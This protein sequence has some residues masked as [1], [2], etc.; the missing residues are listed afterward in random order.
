MYVYTHSKS[1]SLTISKVEV[2]VYGS[3]M[4]GESHRQGLCRSACCNV[5]PS[6]P[7]LGPRPLALSTGRAAPQRVSQQKGLAET[8]ALGMRKRRE[9]RLACCSIVLPSVMHAGEHYTRSLSMHN[10]YTPKE[11]VRALA[12]TLRVPVRVLF[13]Q[14]ERMRLSHDGNLAVQMVDSDVCISGK[15]GILGSPLSFAAFSPLSLGSYTLSP[16]LIDA[17]QDM[18]AGQGCVRNEKPLRMTMTNQ[19]P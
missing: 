11:C 19:G 3:P 10:R 6:C 16:P 14:G 18:T 12:G 2:E 13:G 15:G 8:R 5:C 1:L 9:N 4:Q 7:A 17:D